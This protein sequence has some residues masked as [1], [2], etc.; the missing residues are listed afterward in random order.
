ML[1]I[2]EDNRSGP[3]EIPKL[4][5]DCSADQQRLDGEWSGR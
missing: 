3:H 4:S 2:T 5:P 1:L